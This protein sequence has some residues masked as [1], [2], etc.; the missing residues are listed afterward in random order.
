MTELSK[1][2]VVG[3]VVDGLTGAPLRSVV[4]VWLDGEVS[5]HRD[6]AFRFRYL[7]GGNREEPL[8]TFLRNVQIRSES[9]LRSR[10]ERALKRR[11][12]R[13]DG[14]AEERARSFQ[15]RAADGITAFS[16]SMVFVYLHVGVFGY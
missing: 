9:E 1:D 13:W 5:A 3:R 15:N 14:Y 10:I 2:E 6:L 12:K 8:A 4:A 7:P 11:S 16:G